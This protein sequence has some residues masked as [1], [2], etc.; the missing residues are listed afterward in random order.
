MSRDSVVGIVAMKQAGQGWVQICRCQ[1]F[2]SSLKHPD[3]LWGSG[4]KLFN[5]LPWHIK[6]VVHDNKQFRKALRVFLHTKSFYTIEEYFS[7]G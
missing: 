3:R 1:R 7:H 2:F 6:E 5:H 4:I